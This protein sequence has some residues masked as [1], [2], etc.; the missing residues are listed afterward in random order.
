[1]FTR[2]NL[3]AFVLGTGLLQQQAELPSLPWLWSLLLAMVCYGFWRYFQRSSVLLVIQ[4]IVQWVIFL[5]LGFFWAALNAHW[6]LADTLPLEWEGKDIQVVG[7]VASLPQR[8]ANGIRFKFDVEQVLTE[9]AH[10]PKHIALSWYSQQQANNSSFLPA[11]E[12]AAT[13]AINDSR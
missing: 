9:N 12:A 10:V 3:F 13:L 7:V 11:V 8:H 6:R 1:M 5:A 2:I 4:R